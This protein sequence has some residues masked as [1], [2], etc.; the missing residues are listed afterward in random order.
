MGLAGGEKIF[1]WIVLIPWEHFNSK[2]LFKS[3][4]SEKPFVTV[5][6]QYP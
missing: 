5:P 6:S 4:A 2:T 3:P 1:I